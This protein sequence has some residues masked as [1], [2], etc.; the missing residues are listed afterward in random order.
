MKIVKEVWKVS[1]SSH[2]LYYEDDPK[3]D[4]WTTVNFFMEAVIAAIQLPKGINM[5]RKFVLE[6]TTVVPYEFKVSVVEAETA[7]IIED[8]FKVADGFTLEGKFDNQEEMLE[9][10]DRYLQLADG[11]SG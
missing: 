8:E 2:P 10:L 5:I 3:L 4:V 1:T 6:R 7:Q 9:L 11:A